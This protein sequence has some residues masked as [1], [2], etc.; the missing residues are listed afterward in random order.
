MSELD[1]N[2]MV[3]LTAEGDRAT[4]LSL[5]VYMGNASISVFSNKTNVAR[6]PLSRV[7]VYKLMKNLESVIAGAPGMKIG[8]SFSKYDFETKKSTPLGMLY[9]GK[10]DKS[11]IYFGVQAP[12]N[13]PMKFA[14]RTPASIDNIEPMDDVAR[15][16]LAAETIVEQLRNDIP[17]ASNLT[18]VKRQPQA[19]GGY[20][21]NSGGTGG[22]G[23]SSANLF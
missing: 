12:N 16:I 8:T 23:S 6:L 14:V 18:S 9:V 13:Q 7:A 15:S 3:N 1:F 10:D 4:T 17:H 11:C 20:R 22:G 19:G 21:S 5:G 2:R